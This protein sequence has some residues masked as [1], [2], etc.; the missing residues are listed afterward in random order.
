MNQIEHENTRDDKFRGLFRG[1]VIS[2]QDPQE[3]RRVK[4]RVRGVYDEPVRKDHIP[5]AVPFV[6]G[7]VPKLG[8]EVGVMFQDFDHG[9][10]V[11]FPVE[12]FNKKSLDR[13]LD[14]YVQVVNNKKADVETGVSVVDE[15]IDEPATEAQPDLK[16][17]KNLEVIQE[18]VATE[19]GESVDL[20]TPATGFITERDSEKGKE[21]YSENHPAGTFVE[22]TKD[23]TRITHVKS[24][25]Y[26]VTK[27]DEKRVVKGNFL[28]RVFGYFKKEIT[29]AV[30]I[31]VAGGTTINVDASG[32]VEI[33]SGT[34]DVQIKG[35]N[36]QVDGAV[37]PTGTGPFCA[38]PACL[39][40][41]AVHIGNKATGN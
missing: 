1:Q 20:G 37:T 40:T 32:N 15:T 4:V 14:L 25:K 10:P 18:D 6:K 27:G 2:N 9:S 22:V 17:T 12:W 13:I 41:G 29:G 24:D 19:D 36:L 5:W 7:F 3:L 35:A 28:S 11:Y 34:S 30:S 26:S 16:Y 31:K 21:R 39:F 38:L 33:D 23:G 8:D